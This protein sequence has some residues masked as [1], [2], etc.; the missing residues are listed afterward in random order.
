MSEEYDVYTEIIQQLNDEVEEKDDHI[1]ELQQERDDY[2]EALSEYANPNNWSEEGL[3]GDALR[4]WVEFGS[5][6]PEAYNGYESA[7][8][9]LNKYKGKD[10]E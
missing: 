4:V 8:Q 6:T 9:A 2:K 5:A 1:E 10:N 7:Q 3:A